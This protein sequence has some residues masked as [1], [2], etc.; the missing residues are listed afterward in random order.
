MDKLLDAGRATVD[1]AARLKI[2]RQ[3]SDKLAKDLPYLFLT[4]FENTSLA[5][6]KVKGLASV[7]DGL[8]RLGPVWK[9]K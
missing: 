2:Y 6:P 8:L 4:Y 5:S 3:I 9:D 7:P 1:S